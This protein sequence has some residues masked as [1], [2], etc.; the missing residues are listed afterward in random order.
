MYWY[1]RAATRGHTWAIYCLAR[2]LES[3]SSAEQKAS[4]EWLKKGVSLQHK[5]SVMRFALLEAKKGKRG[6]QW[7]EMACTMRYI[8]A[9]TWLVREATEGRLELQGE[10][11]IA[12]LQSLINEL[13]SIADEL[14]PEEYCY[15]PEDYWAEIRPVMDESLPV[16]QW[17]NHRP[18]M[19]TLSYDALFF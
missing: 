5:A 14:L 4:R 6:I 11:T 1:R 2:L 17:E 13:P 12:H 8:T 18:L 10:V 15:L 3:G 19:V 16:W 9:L 7:L